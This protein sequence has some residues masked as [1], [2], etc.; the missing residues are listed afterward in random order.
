MTTVA[1]RKR[2]INY[3]QVADDKKVK[4]LYALLETELMHEEYTS[5]EQYNKELEEAEAAFKKGDYIS[6]DAMKK[7]VKQ[8]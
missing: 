3:M 2:L 8:W 5:I 6:N 7:R 1:I 4:G